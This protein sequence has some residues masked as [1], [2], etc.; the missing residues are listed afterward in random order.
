MLFMIKEAHPLPNS[1][2]YNP[3]LLAFLLLL[4]TVT[5]IMQCT[6]KHDDCKNLNISLLEAIWPHY[7]CILINP[8]YTVTKPFQQA[9]IL[10]AVHDKHIPK[11]YEEQSRRLLYWIPDYY[12]G[13]Y[14][15]NKALTSERPS[16]GKTKYK[17]YPEET[18]SI[19]IF[20]RPRAV[21]QP[22]PSFLQVATNSTPQLQSV[23]VNF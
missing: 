19:V 5:Q 15:G 13:R 7:I 16:H 2:G 17:H 14:L 21:K 1:S 22:E 8:V 6:Q 10:F 4:N 12:F 3:L 18:K 23:Q 20:A 9:S 11:I